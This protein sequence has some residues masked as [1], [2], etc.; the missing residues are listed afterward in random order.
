MDFYSSAAQVIPVLLVVLVFEVRALESPEFTERFWDRLVGALFCALVAL[1]E[2]AA[3]ATLER[4]NAWGWAPVAVWVALI[5][6]AFVL[7]AWQ[8]QF[9]WLRAT[10]RRLQ[11]KD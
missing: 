7:L 9:R 11:R 3:L 2:F 8:P 1:G 5:A 4:G 10:Q 6:E